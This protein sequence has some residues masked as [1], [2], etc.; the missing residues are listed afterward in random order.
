MNT[1]ASFNGVTYKSTA[2][3]LLLCGGAILTNWMIQHV[4]PGPLRHIPRSAVWGLAVGLAALTFQ[5]VDKNA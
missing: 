4:A 1:T 2:N 5:K 3:L